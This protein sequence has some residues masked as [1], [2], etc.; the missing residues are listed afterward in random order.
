MR[1]K[2]LLLALSSFGAL[3]ASTCSAA[4]PVEKLPPRLPIHIETPRHYDL[5]STIK[6]LKPTTVVVGAGD[7]S[8]RALATL[9]MT[10]G[11]LP[12]FYRIRRVTHRYH[13]RSWMVRHNR[14]FSG[15]VSVVMPHMLYLP[16]V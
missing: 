3:F 8:P 7:L 1:S 15:R 14:Y 13:S 4:L 6:F 9:S 2:L 12:K 16:I 11:I 5:I 10:D